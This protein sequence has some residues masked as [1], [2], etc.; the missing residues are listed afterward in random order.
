[1]KRPASPLDETGATLARGDYG[2]QAAACVENLAQAL[3]AAG[4]TLEDVISTRVLV[5]SSDREDLGT[6]WAVV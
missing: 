6:A 3:A 1:M 5:A 2:G 4:A